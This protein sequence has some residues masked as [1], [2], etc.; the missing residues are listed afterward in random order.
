[1]KKKSDTIKKKSDKLLT[2][3]NIILGIII[4]ALIGS[5]FFDFFGAAKSTESIGCPQTIPN[6]V[7]SNVVYSADGV[8]FSDQRVDHLADDPNVKYEIS[9]LF[10]NLG[11]KK[12]IIT[13]LALTPGHLDSLQL[14]TLDE[15]IEIEPQSMKVLQLELPSGAYH[16]IDAY[17]DNP[18]N[19]NTVWHDLTGHDSTAGT[20]DDMM[21]GG[22]GLGNGDITEDN[23]STPD[24]TGNLT[25]ETP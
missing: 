25:P 23:Q 15:P 11:N 8:A 1:M 6:L 17:S 19:G 24:V 4:I 14:T 7:I 21:E 9:A 22:A 3:G 5:L 12:I 2:P 16:K 13:Q 18:C 10:R 20:E